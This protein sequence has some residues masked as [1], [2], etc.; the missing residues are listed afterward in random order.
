MRK[1]T[2]I[3]IVILFIGLVLPVLGMLNCSGFNEGSGSVR[4]CIIDCTFLREY[5]NFYFGWLV[6]SAFAIFIPVFVYIGFVIFMANFI[7][8]QYNEDEN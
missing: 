2:N 3:K 4:S 1:K 5:A 7:S 8:K 6:I